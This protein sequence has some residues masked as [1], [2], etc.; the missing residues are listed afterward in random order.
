MK[1]VKKTLQKMSYND[2]YLGEKSLEEELM[3]EVK[4]LTYDICRT[5]IDHF[6]PEKLKKQKVSYKKTSNYQNP[7]NKD[8][9]SFDRKESRNRRTF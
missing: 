6:I 5:I 9:K 3:K 7:G 4:R 8:G 1:N 2:V